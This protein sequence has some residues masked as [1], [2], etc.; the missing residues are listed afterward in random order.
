MNHTVYTFREINIQYGFVS[1]NI[2]TTP[3]KAQS[4]NDGKVLF[5]KNSCIFPI[6]ST[7]PCAGEE[8]SGTIYCKV[9]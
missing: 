8:K 1:D 9:K 3:C 5:Q 6:D 4:Y 2:V 7:W